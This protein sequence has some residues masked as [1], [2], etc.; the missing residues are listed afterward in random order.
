MKW[1]FLGLG[2]AAAVVGIAAVMRG[3][4]D[5]RST[6]CVDGGVVHSNDGAD[7]PKVIESTE[8]TEFHCTFSLY[9]V[10]EPG[11]LGNGKYT[12]SAILQN[13]A[14]SCCIKWQER[15]GEGGERIFTADSSF[16]TRLQELVDAH[17]FAQHNGCSHSV[18]GLP[19]MYGAKLNICYASGESIYTYDNQHNF[20]EQKAMED[21]FTLFTS[22]NEKQQ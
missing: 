14:V 16:M 8:I 11:K 5:V 10:A 12:C 18:S 13:G 2:L 19:D 1:L 17:A 20:L 21:L 3:R 7:S 6:D 22:W 9:A 15:T 4:R